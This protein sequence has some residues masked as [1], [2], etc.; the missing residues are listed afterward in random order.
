MRNKTGSQRR[1]SI[2]ALRYDVII[3]CQL[4]V[5]ISLKFCICRFS[6]F[7]ILHQN[8]IAT[9]ISYRAILL[10]TISFHNNWRGLYE[11]SCSCWLGLNNTCPYLASTQISWRYHS[12]TFHSFK[13]LLD[14]IV[15][16]SKYRLY[17][18]IMMNTDISLELFYTMLSIA[19]W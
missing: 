6:I 13:S 11:M 17:F 14:V 7:V 3:S 12:Q 4:N 8:K 18:L 16:G 5:I 2:R 19:N 1:I 15:C 9:L 10:Q